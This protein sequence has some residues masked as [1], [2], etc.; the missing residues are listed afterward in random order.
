MGGL[1][2][3]QLAREYLQRGHQVTVFTLDMETT[4][5]RWIEGDRLRVFVGPYRSEGRARDLF[6]VERRSIEQAI[7]ASDVPFVHAHWTYEFALGAL[8]SGRPTLVT[9]HDAPMRI[10]SLNPSPYRALRT[11][12]AAQTLVKA[13]HL[14]AVSPYVIRHL[15]LMGYLKHVDLV[16]N[17][18]A[19]EDAIPARAPAPAD[20]LA[21]A[22]ILNGGWQGLK[23]GKRLLRAFAIV[24][25]ALP[26]ATLFL[27]GAGLGAGEDAQ[28]W[29]GAQG[30][31]TGVIWRG[32]RPH[33]QIIEDLQHRTDVLV[34][35][36]LEESFGLTIL[37]AMALGLP[38][39]AG[40]RS[41]AVPWVTDF[42]RGALLVD[43]TSV[44]ALALG[45]LR[46]GTEPDLSVPLAQHGHAYARE[47]FTLTRVADQYESLYQ[48]LR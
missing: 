47:H 8:A 15:K 3:V 20:R 7:W 17:G 18:M 31:T 16:P 35:P 38:V 26:Q 2:V 10:L 33:A 13:K 6:A 41:G 23:N 4:E 29:A 21:F 37:E 9:A 30:L 36:A 5:P 25:R 46:L 48:R 32:Y 22:S 14:T 12:M 11:V 43:V 42:G 28:T 44:D 34:H 27:Y 45:M 40:R 19:I 39:V 24:R 1:P